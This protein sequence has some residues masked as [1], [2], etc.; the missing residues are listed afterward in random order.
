MKV[1]CTRCSAIFY[2]WTLADSSKRKCTRCGGTVELVENVPISK[3]SDVLAMRL[4]H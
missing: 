2:G 4:R 3:L 1:T